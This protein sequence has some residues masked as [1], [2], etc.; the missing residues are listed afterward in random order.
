MAHLIT[1][2][3][4]QLRWTNPSS[5][6]NRAAAAAPFKEFSSSPGVWRGFCSACGT[7]FSWRSDDTAEE[8]IEL[9]IGTIDEVCLIGD[10]TAK[11]SSER[12]GEPGV[13]EA[14]LDAEEGRLGREICAPTGGQMF[15]R[16]AVRG[17][18]DARLVGKRFVEVSQK[19]LEVPE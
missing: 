1:I 9:L 11:V 17:A 18:T 10:R 7:A 3:P 12:M 14:V 6:G 4:S 15:V 19:G 5:D 16:N 13:W 8:E 2:N